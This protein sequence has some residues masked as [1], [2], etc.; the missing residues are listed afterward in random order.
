MT[1]DRERMVADLRALVRI[2]SITG[3]E[4]AA[5][6]WAAAA[7]RGVGLT[8]EELAPDPIAIR[9]DPAWPG[10]ETPRGS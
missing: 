5:A 2:P 7:I 9:A 10:Q 6:V 3:S 4:E 8:V 1:I